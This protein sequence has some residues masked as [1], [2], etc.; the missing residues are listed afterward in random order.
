MSKW[1]VNSLL[2]LSTSVCRCGAGTAVGPSNG[3][4]MHS[5]PRSTPS[6]C[7]GQ[8]VWDKHLPALACPP[9]DVIK[10]FLPDE[11]GQQTVAHPCGGVKLNIGLA[12]Y[13]VLSVVQ[14][15][16]DQAARCLG[17]HA[18]VGR[19]KMLETSFRTK[20]IHIAGLQET[21]APEGQC[22]C[23]VFA[24]FCTGL[25]ASFNYGCEVWID[26]ESTFGQRKQ[27]FRLSPAH[28]VVQHAEPT[29]LVLRIKNHAVDWQFGCFH[30]LHRAHSE[31]HRAHWWL[32]VS[33]ICRSLDKNGQ[34]LLFM[35]GNIR[36]GTEPPRA[37]STHHAD[38]EDEASSIAHRLMLELRTF[39]PSTFAQNMHGPGET[40]FHKRSSQADRSD[41]VCDPQSWQT[42][43]VD[44]WVDPE[45]NVGHKC[46]D[47]LCLVVQV[48]V[49]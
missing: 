34:W 11:L 28:V 41:F 8:L 4:R 10:P 2:C 13:N 44:A 7:V 47:H 31:A 37:V 9:L 32:R 46:M 21:R 30:G 17:L 18:E 19:V 22:R 24:R 3:F 40:L 43:P 49:A 23:G 42:M 25:D 26:A 39:V 45:I 15:K 12:S 14:P 29:F 35:D 5:G 48:E 16:N 6:T 20:G 38:V 1:Q 27:S 33:A 36:L